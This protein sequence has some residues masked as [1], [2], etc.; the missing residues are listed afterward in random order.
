MSINIQPKLSMKHFFHLITLSAILLTGCEQPKNEETPP[1][2]EPKIEL[3]DQNNLALP[4]EGGNFTITYSIANPVD[5]GQIS[6]EAADT[7]I[8]DFSYAEEGAITFVADANGQSES[9]SQ[10]I[11]LVYTYG[12]GKTVQ[13]QINAV[14][15]AAAAYDYDFTFDIFTGIYYGDIFGVNDE[16]SYYTWISDMNFDAGGYPKANGTYYLFDIFAPAP[17]DTENPLPPAGTYTLGESKATAEMTFTPDYSLTI[18]TDAEGGNVYKRGFTEGTLT[19]SYEG[20]N[21][22]IEAILTDEEGKTHHV[23]FNGAAVYTDEVTGGNGTLNKDLIINASFASAMFSSHYGNAT[24]IL[25]QFSDMTVNE[26]SFIPPGSHLSVDISVPYSEEG[27]LGDGTYT[28]APD[29]GAYTF[30]P[31]Q[32]YSGFYLGTYVQYVK[33]AFNILIGI[34]DDGTITISREADI[35]T[36]KCELKTAEGYNVTCNYSGAIE[37]Q[38]LNQT[39]GQTDNGSRSMK[40]TNMYR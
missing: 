24:E 9:R 1:A 37:I 22:V 2:D 28:V 35:Y 12:D 7:W 36:I 4:A 14:Q 29:G 21:M 10:A 27:I 25:M 38:G 34:I 33:E 26:G 40:K 5:G 15:D 3:G 17:E 18:K 32:D 8:H 20:G 23:Q 13:A 19:V 16:H 39:A 11:T 30:F 31:G 6:A